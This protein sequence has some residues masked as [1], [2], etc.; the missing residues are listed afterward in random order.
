VRCWTD[1][2]RSFHTRRYILHVVRLFAQSSAMT[3]SFCSINRVVDDRLQAALRSALKAKGSTA[4]RH[5]TRL[6]RRAK[7][8]LKATKYSGQENAIRLIGSH[9]LFA[10]IRKTQANVPLQQDRRDF[11]TGARLKSAGRTTR[12]PIWTRHVYILWKVVLVITQGLE[13]A[14]DR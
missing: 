10:W 2:L 3:D 7:A 1:D 6:R 8:A 12:P 14:V 9:C 4:V 5:R 13:S 11:D